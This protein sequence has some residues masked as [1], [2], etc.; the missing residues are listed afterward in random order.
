MSKISEFITESKF[1]PEVIAASV[2]LGLFI[3][4]F[5]FGVWVGLPN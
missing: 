4:G 1:T 5:G 2:L 3:V